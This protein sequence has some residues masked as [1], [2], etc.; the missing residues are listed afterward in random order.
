LSQ[1][2]RALP[3]KSHGRFRTWFRKV[4]NVRGGGLYACGFAITFVILETA[5]IIDDV[6]DVGLLFNGEVVA[7]FLNFI[8]DS[9]QNTWKAFVWPMFV[10]QFAS[11]WGA[12]GLGLAFWLF[13][14]YVKKH[15]E[16][17]LLSDDESKETAEAE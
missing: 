17:W 5:S 12:I 6:K 14:T 16:A 8:I 7:F 2:A 9:F 10:V 4:W 3:G 1:E 11:P 15:V 13:P